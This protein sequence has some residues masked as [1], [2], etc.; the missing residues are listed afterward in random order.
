MLSIHYSNVTWTSWRLRSPANR[1]FAQRFARLGQ[2]YW[3]FV[4]RTY[5]P[6]EVSLHK[7]PAMHA[8][9]VFISWRHIPVCR[10]LPTRFNENTNVS[11]IMMTPGAPF[12]NMV[13]PAWISNHMTNKVW[14][15]ITYPFPNFNGATI[16]VLG[17]NKLFHPTIYNGCDYISTLGLKLI[18]VSK[19]ATNMWWRMYLEKI[20]GLAGNLRFSDS[21]AGYLWTKIHES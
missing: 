16:D 12:T 21:G 15:E 14:D 17:M 13:I 6:P 2:F 4:K 8:G 10:K 11:R 20:S 18:Y 1:V 7:G 3:S 9:S 5:R 19:G